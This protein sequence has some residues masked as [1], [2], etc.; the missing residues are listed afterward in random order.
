[1]AMRRPA[2]VP[3]QDWFWTNVDKS[4]ECWTWTGSLS[5]GTS[6]YGSANAPGR[7]VHAHR[8]SWELANG[9]V[10]DGLWVLHHCDNPPCVRPDHLHL[11]TQSENLRAAVSRGRHY[12]SKKTHC[13]KG[14]EYAGDNLYVWKGRRYCRTCVRAYGRANYWR[15]KAANA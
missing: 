6:G 3:W 8:L 2:N 10:P 13:T 9:P 15:H 7:R 5:R 1:M 4:G 11:G 12:W 14:H